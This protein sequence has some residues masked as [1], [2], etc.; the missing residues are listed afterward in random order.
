M[1]SDWHGLKKNACCFELA[2]AKD[3]KSSK[4]GKCMTVLAEAKGRLHTVGT[5]SQMV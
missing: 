5:V 4:V 2:D 1:S 3:R